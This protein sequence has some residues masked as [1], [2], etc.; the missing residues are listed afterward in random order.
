MKFPHSRTI[1]FLAAALLLASPCFPALAQGQLQLS[2]QKIKAGL[3]YNFL[4]N[5]AWPPAKANGPVVVCVFGASDPFGGYLQPIEDRTVSQREITLSYIRKVEEAPGCHAIF[6]GL[7]ARASW[8]A[9]QAALA[10]KGVLTVGDF[11]GFSRA[12]GMIEFGRED[13]RIQIKLNA[14][15]VSAAGLRIYDSLRRLAKT[16]QQPQRAPAPQGE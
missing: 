9:L 7:G 13:E 2:E 5:T 10:G 15:A 3:I 6:V 14:G 8:P 16:T 4:K 1:A 11:T 12:G